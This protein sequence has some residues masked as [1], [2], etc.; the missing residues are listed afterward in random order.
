MPR[1]VVRV[2]VAGG[3][4]GQ[5]DERTVDEGPG[6]GHPLLLAAGQLVGQVVAL[7]GQPDQVEDLGHLGGDHVLGAADDL[8]G[9]G[10]VLEHRLVGQEPE[11]LEDAADVAAQV[12]DPPL[13]Q[14]PDLLARLPDPPASRHLLAQQEPDE[15]GLARSGRPDEEDELA[16]VD[17]DGEVAEGDCRALVRL[18]DV[19]N[20]IIGAKSR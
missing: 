2:E 13:G 10:H 8:E 7:L 18:G 15:G 17:L 6:D 9:E 3:L 11:V 4:V 19:S 20:L 14:M 16:L 1:L 12:G 5:E